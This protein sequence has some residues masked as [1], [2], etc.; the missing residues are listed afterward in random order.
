MTKSITAVLFINLYN[1]LATAYWNLA[2]KVY[3]LQIIYKHKSSKCWQEYNT[4]TIRT[5]LLCK[6]NSGANVYK[7]AFT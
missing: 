2:V 4:A 5:N 1:L 3:F 7:L 6:S